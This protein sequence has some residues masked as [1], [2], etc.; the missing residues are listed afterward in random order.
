MK[1]NKIKRF[2]LIFMALATFPFAGW[3]ESRSISAGDTLLIGDIGLNVGNYIISTSD[4]GF[5]VAGYLRNSANDGFQGAL[6]KVN[7]K[8]ETT[9]L[10]RYRS[11]NDSRAW[12]V[13]ETAGGEFMVVGYSNDFGEGRKQDVW[14][15]R[16]SKEG[17]LIWEKNLGGSENDLAWDIKLLQ[18]G[19]FVIAAQT[20]SKGAGNI[21]AW[22]IKVNGNGEVIW[23]N[24]FGTAGRERIFSI[25]EGI[26]GEIYTTG[27]HTPGPAEGP[28][29]AYTLAI[30]PG[31]GRL[32]W[33]DYLD[34]GENDT[35]HGVVFDKRGGVW[36]AGYTSS[37]GGGQ[38]DGFLARY[39]EGKVT[40]FFT[41]GGKRMNRIMN[42]VHGQEEELWLVGYS[43]SYNDG[44]HF[45]M[46]ITASDYSGREMVQPMTINGKGNDRAVHLVFDKNRIL[47]TGTY[48]QD[49]QGNNSSMIVIDCEF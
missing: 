19:N 22:V 12:S 2:I 18:D 36:V 48:A 9:W 35:G 32:I 40:D 42:V 7:A 34:K 31:D 10:R 49:G 29:D 27:I 30:N 20:E 17:E 16:T 4:G 3:A 15:F 25:T 44:S 41:Y 45:D 8:L 21:D 33:E 11:R 47:V 43:N 14:L 1:G 23:D 39:L 28:I 6:L 24:T 38:Q 26:T 5:L 37:T 46:W 13:C